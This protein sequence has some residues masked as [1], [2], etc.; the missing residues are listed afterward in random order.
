M[1]PDYVTLKALHIGFA[2]VSFSI[3]LLRAAWTFYGSA[4]LQWRWVQ[5]APHVIDSLFMA[6]G[7]A[8]A[9]T[10]H[11][12]PFV[13]GWLTAKIFALFAYILLGSLALKRASSAQGRRIALIAA[14]I[15]FAY[16][17]GVAIAHDPRSWLAAR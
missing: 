14:F 11:Q 12:Y 10:I 13:N 4:Q 2:A 6:S 17:V 7:I 5:V 1:M 9:I 8:L 16:I 15:V 3:F